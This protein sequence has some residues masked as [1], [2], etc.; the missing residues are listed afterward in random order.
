LVVEEAV[1]EVWEEG[2][3]LALVE[4]VGARIVGINNLMNLAFP[5]SIRNVRNAALP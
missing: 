2:L 5:V 3:P 4:N 1:E